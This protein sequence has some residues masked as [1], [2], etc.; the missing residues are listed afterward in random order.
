MVELK[1]RSLQ[2][3][4]LSFQGKVRSKARICLRFFQVL[5]FLPAA[6]PPIPECCQDLERKKW[7]ESERQETAADKLNDPDG[8]SHSPWTWGLWTAEALLWTLW[9]RSER[10][11]L[12]P[13]PSP[14]PPAPLLL[15]DETWKTKPLQTNS[16]HVWFWATCITCLLNVNKD[17]SWLNTV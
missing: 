11:Q 17:D 9:R 3:G 2:L 14:Q 8:H 1:Y 5:F 16:Y 7:L 12:F 10:C 13:P 15:P 6:A 4:S